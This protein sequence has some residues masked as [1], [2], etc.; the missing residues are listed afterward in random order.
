ME[1]GHEVAARAGAGRLA[2]ELQA[3]GAAARQGGSDIRDAVGHMVEAGAALGQE[4][5][6]GAIVQDGREQLDPPVA[7]LQHRYLRALILQGGAEADREAEDAGIEGQGLVQVGRGDADVI[8]VRE[9]RS[10]AARLA[11]WHATILS[12][13]DSRRA[14]Y[15]GGAP[16]PEAR[17]LADR[18]DGRQHPV[19]K[20]LV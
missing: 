4:L 11:I 15:A 19:R 13:Y 12:I 1:E 6:D 9:E 2:D 14:A 5:A 8:D 18:A 3:G 7:A 17:R 20:R 10:R 16:L